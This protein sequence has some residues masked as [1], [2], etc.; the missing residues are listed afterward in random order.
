MS[1]NESSK[2]RLGRDASVLD[3]ELDTLALK[4]CSLPVKQGWVISTSSFRN[5]RR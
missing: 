4:R 2:P 1:G 3:V 5:R